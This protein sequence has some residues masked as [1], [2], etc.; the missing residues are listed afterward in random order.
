[1]ERHFSTAIDGPSMP[2][3]KV[4]LLDLAS[5]APLSQ[6][7]VL[8]NSSLAEAVSSV[9]YGDFLLVSSEFSGLDMD[10]A[11]A[12]FIEDGSGNMEKT[13]EDSQRRQ[14]GEIKFGQLLLSSSGET[15]ASELVVVKAFPSSRTAANDFATMT[16]LNDLAK[17][18]TNHSSFRPIGF[19]VFPEGG[20]SAV[21]TVYDQPVISYDNVFLNPD[22]QPS[23]RKAGSALSYI[24]FALGYLHGKGISFG[25]TQ[26]KN[27]A[28]GNTG[29]RYNDTESMRSMVNKRGQINPIDAYEKCR[30]NITTLLRSLRKGN[31]DYSEEIMLH[32]APVYKGMVQ[33]PGSAIPEEAR[34]GVTDVDEILEDV[35]S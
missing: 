23:A 13:R 27:F 12:R 25:D 20:L 17:P 34:L 14:F 30:N 35:M 6:D 28:K 3:G 33:Q 32:F 7:N 15:E 8:E 5:H 21:I 1:M 11:V 26:V 10:G 9:S 19:Y 16:Y 29:V 2:T 31:R 18:S 24:G 4:E 22:M